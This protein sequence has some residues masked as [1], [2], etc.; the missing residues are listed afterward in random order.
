MKYS[1]ALLAIKP[2]VF[3]F[4]AELKGGRVL[5]KRCDACVC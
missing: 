1:S 2:S 4:S 3:E 5:H